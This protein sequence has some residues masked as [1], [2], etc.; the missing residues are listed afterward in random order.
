MDRHAALLEEV[1]RLLGPKPQ[2]Q[3][4]ALP[5]LFQLVDRGNVALPVDPTH[6]GCLWVLDR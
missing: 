1:G 3:H 6:L 2:K 5:D 4:L